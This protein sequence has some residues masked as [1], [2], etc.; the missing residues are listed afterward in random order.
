MEFFV[1]HG[2]TNMGSLIWPYARLIQN[3]TVAGVVMYEDFSD[4]FTP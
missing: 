1:S 2:R 4:Y 3:G